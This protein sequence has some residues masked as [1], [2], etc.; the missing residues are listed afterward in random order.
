MDSRCELLLVM[1]MLVMPV[2]PHTR[3][4]RVDDVIPAFPEAQDEVAVPNAEMQQVLQLAARLA[5]SPVMG[6]QDE[7]ERDVN[8]Q[9]SQ[10]VEQPDDREPEVQV[11]LRDTPHAIQQD[12]SAAHEQRNE[13]TVID[14]PNLENIASAA[15][16][17]SAQRVYDNAKLQDVERTKVIARQ[18]REARDRLLAEQERAE[19][20]RLQQELWQKDQAAL[21]RPQSED[22]SVQTK[23][24]EDVAE[25]VYNAEVLISGGAKS[26]NTEAA[27]NVYDKAN[28]ERL[29]RKKTEAR[30]RKQAE[31]KFK[32]D[33][34]HAQKMRARQAQLEKERAERIRTE[35]SQHQ[36]VVE[37]VLALSIFL[38]TPAG[39]GEEAVFRWLDWAGLRLV[40]TE[41]P[42][43][44]VCQRTMS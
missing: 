35:V 41:V 24:D 21:Q 13:A 6:A 30:L 4:N 33:R 7:A 18:Q 40:H 43:W 34:E 5:V 14:V 19:K 22:S 2:R 17:D 8:T 37:I 20:L 38:Q 42:R 29:E 28:T 3:S 9:D 16:Q 44:N 36:H 15:S 25:L 23:V 32:A 27:R 10:Q 39:R 31:E 12:T 1:V 11:K 26:I